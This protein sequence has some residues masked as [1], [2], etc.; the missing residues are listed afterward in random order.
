MVARTLKRGAELPI[1]AQAR[2]VM[3]QGFG[4]MVDAV[5]L[6]NILH[7]EQPVTLLRHARNTLR[8]GGELLVI[9]WRHDIATPRGPATDIR[10]RPQ[11]IAGWGSQGRFDR[12]RSY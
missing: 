7:C 3:E 11:Q 6:F 8:N 9:H 1:I 12:R 4:V 5:L 10:P 2:D